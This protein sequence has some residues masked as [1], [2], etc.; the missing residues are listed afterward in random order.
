MIKKSVFA[1]LIMVVLLSLWGQRPALAVQGQADSSPRRFDPSSTNLQAQASLAERPDAFTAPDMPSVGK[2]SVAGPSIKPGYYQTSEYM[3]GSVAV[4]IVLVQSNGKVDPSTEDWTLDQKRLVFDKVT[5]ALNWWAALEPRAHLSFVVDDHFSAPLPTDVEPI[6]R[7]YTDE[8]YWVADAM[9]ALGYTAISYF[10]R[11]RDYNNALR[12]NYHTDWAFT[13]FVVNDAHDGDHSFSNDYFAYAYVGGPFMVMTYNNANYGPENMDAVAAHEIGHIFYALDQYA[14]AGQSCVSRSGY[15]AVENQN[16]QSGACAMNVESI[17]RGQVSPYLRHALDPYAAGQ[18]GWHVSNG[19][20][21]LDPLH[22]DLPITITDFVQSGNSVVV[23]GTAEIVP[24]PSPS[25]A[26]VT[27]NTLTGVQ[28]RLDQGEWQLALPDDEAFD[29][30]TETYHLATNVITPGLH[31]LQVT[32]LDSAGNI[33]MQFASRTVAILDPVDG[34]LIT[35][36]DSSAR[37]AR[38]GQRLDVTGVAY[39]LESGAVTNVQYRVNGGEWHSAA[40][41]DGKFDSR[42][43]AFTVELDSLDNS[44][45]LI[46][47]RATDSTGKTETTLA[48][49]NVTVK[50]TYTVFL[51]TIAR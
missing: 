40:P 4:G 41:Q 10:A 23:S 45:Y 7:P 30:V 13:I 34:G 22:T 8:K 1:L 21:I 3:A 24:Y 25:R 29:G 33:S 28:V 36:F 32:A 35:T 47:A 9:G 26:S 51:P 12:D 38:V 17:M 48:S 6:T 5:T 44:S 46:E 16:S 11:V 20:N 37:Q 43:E 15:L 49:L 27:I 50:P 19:D 14:A 42:Q 2:L 31:T 39:Q 18:I